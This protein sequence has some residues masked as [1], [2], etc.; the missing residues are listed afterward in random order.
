MISF[1]W[2]PFS[3]NALITQMQKS[4]F[5]LATDGSNDNGMLKMNPLA[6]RIFDINLGKVKTSLLDMCVLK[7]GTVE[8]LFR[9]IDNCMSSFGIPW[10]NCVA[11]GVDNT[12]VN[13][14]KNNSIKTRV[15]ERNSSVYFNGCPCHIVHNT[16][17]AASS[18]FSSATGFDVEDMMV[19][20]F[21][22]FDYSTKRK[23]KLAEYAEF[24]D[25]EYRQI[26]KHVS[27]RWLSLEK[28]VTRTLTQYASLKS[29][30]LSEQESTARF[31]RL[32]DAFKD[33]ITEVYLLFFQAALQI[34]MQLNLFLQ[35][36][37]PL[38]GAMNQAIRRFLRLLACKFVAPVTVKAAKTNE[39]LLDP[40]NHLY[41]KEI[42][43]GYQIL[44]CLFFLA[45]QN[46]LHL[47]NGKHFVN[48]MP[49]SCYNQ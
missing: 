46:S 35:R 13:M 21:Y 12:S 5:S 37:E 17:S 28:S 44:E 18:A 24:C 14:G 42:F 33:P 25:Q 26:V 31:K 45:T 15:L 4:P 29:Y 47:I 2:F 1:L 38:I 48:T 49:C 36:E 23:N 3:R 40:V 8:E 34:F 16:A 7:G 39:E 22:W 19:D 9:T 30:F 10:D 11:V 27:T 6:V 43:L 41:G 20:L 32:K